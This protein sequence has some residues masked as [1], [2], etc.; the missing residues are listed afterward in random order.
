MA[1]VYQSSGYLNTKNCAAPSSASSLQLPT[2][3]PTE[4]GDG[5]TIGP[6]ADPDNGN[7]ASSAGDPHIRSFSGLGYACKGQGEFTLLASLDS[8]FKVQGRFTGIDEQRQITV[9]AGIAVQNEGY[10]I[11]QVSE[12]KTRTGPT[13]RLGSCPVHLFVDGVLQDLGSARLPGINLRQ[14]G[15]KVRILYDSG[16]DVVVVQRG[17]I[18]WFAASLYRRAIKQQKD[19]L[20]SLDQPMETLTIDGSPKMDHPCLSLLVLPLD[21]NTARQIG[22]CQ[23]SIPCLPMR[24]ERQTT[25]STWTQSTRKSKPC[26]TETRIVC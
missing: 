2:M 3:S 19:L 26:A 17:S 13:T 21:T 9:T 11:V 12:A 7:I 20:V 22:V 25:R 24:M 15:S 23:S 14:N 1:R 5:P 16:V 4:G 18:C 10:P 8:G 6:P